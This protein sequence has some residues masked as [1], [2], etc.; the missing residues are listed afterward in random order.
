[1]SCTPGYNKRERALML[2]LHHLMFKL[3]KLDPA[4]CDACREIAAF[5]A[6]PGY[7]PMEEPEVH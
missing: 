1:M 7:E 3:H 5:I 2:A 6:V 4:R